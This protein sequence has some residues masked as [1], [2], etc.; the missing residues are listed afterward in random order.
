MSKRIIFLSLVA[1]LVLVSCDKGS[2]NQSAASN[3][4]AAELKT[5]TL[6]VDKMTC[7]A[8]PITV[9]LALKKVPGVASAKVDFKTKTAVVS[10]DPKKTTIKALTDATTKAGYPS[11]VKPGS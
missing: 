3:L 10:F 7:A 11:A 4:P 8:C 9:R 5:V 1:T 6:K 2:S